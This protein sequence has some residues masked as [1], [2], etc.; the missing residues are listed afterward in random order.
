MMR[1]SFVTAVIAASLLVSAGWGQGLPDELN[2]SRSNTE[3]FH[4]YGVSTF[5]AHS[6][7]DFLPT[8]A[9]APINTRSQYGAGGTVGWQH[10]RSKL[11]AAL[12]YSA[13][14]NGTI[15]NSVLN[16]LNQSLVLDLI[17]PIGTKWDISLSITGQ[18][19]SL[20]QSIFDPTVL[21]S[22]SQSSSTFDDLAAAMSV[23]QFSSSQSAVMLSGSSGTSSPTLNVLL[24]SRVL[25]YAAHA[26]VGYEHS[27]RLRFQFG[28]F[29]IGGQHRSSNDTTGITNNYVMPRTLGGIATMSMSYSLSP[30]TNLGLG[31]GQNY[32]SSRY[33][34][35]S[36]TDAT[37]SIGRKMGKSWFLSVNGGGSFT[38]NLQQAGGSAPMRQMLWGGS[39]GYRTRTFTLLALYNRSA[40][41][42]ATAAIGTNT[43]YSGAWNWRHPR[44]NWGLYATY[45]RHDT[46]NTGFS[47]LW[48]WQARAGVSRALSG[49]LTLLIDGSYVRSRGVFLARENGVNVQAI[50]ISLGW[51]PGLTRR[52]PAPTD[53]IENLK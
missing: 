3:G 46:T 26:S 38:E 29:A 6:T 16:N 12:R 37:V 27:S 48:G 40:Y 52:S 9:T 15:Q 44:S 50:R 11:S 53:E 51:T 42:A 31:V 1:K 41:D 43:I 24:G 4:I 34:R 21:G 32:T 7:Y 39:I 18:E 45:M 47:S 20:N 33:Q 5:F 17:R 30:R 10:F 14:Y 22:I 28:S 13:N 49:N 25:T 19:L 8:P 36:S 2:F 35:A 23:G